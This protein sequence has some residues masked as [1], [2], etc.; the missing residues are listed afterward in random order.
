MVVSGI[1]IRPGVVIA[2]AALFSCNESLIS[3][4]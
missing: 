4:E 3:L 1:E 2:L